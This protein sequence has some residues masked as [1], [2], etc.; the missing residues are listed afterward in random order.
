MVQYC[1]DNVVYLNNNNIDINKFI[2]KTLNTIVEPISNATFTQAGFSTE[3]IAVGRLTLFT[4]MIVPADSILVI[5]ST[6][7]SCTMMN[8]LVIG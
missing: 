8:R 5:T 1:L 7:S 6:L 2:Y 3:T 4:L